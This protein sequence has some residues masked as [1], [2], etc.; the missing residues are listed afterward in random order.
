MMPDKNCQSCGMPFS[1]KSGGL[2]KDGTRSKLF[3][4]QAIKMQYP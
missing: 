2:E 4:S 1:K 3:Y